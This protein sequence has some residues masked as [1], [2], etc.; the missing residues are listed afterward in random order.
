MRK[1][2]E[3]SLAEGFKAEA[4]GFA[5]LGMTSESKALKSIFFGQ[6]RLTCIGTGS[7]LIVIT[8]SVE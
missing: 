7:R 8:Q 5:D 2:L 1:G 4:E 6:V 3:D